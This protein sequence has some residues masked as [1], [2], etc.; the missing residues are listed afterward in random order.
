[1]Y[2]SAVEDAFAGDIDFAQLVKVY[3]AAP[4]GAEVRYSPAE[5]KGTQK[6]AITGC[7]DAKHVSTSYVERVQPD[8]ADGD[9]PV[10][11]VD[12]RLFQEA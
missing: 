1:M 4:E 7:P 9:P 3:G 5:C 11:P 2:L 6:H 10:H 12:Q 8:R